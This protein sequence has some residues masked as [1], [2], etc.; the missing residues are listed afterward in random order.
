LPGRQAHRSREALEL[1][2]QGQLEHGHRSR[3]A[4]T[5]PVRHTSGQERK[6][7]A[8]NAPGLVAAGDL[9]FS[10]EQVKGFV[11]A[12]VHVQRRR[13]AGRRLGLDQRELTPGFGAGCL[14]CHEMTEEPE[15]VAFLGLE[16]VAAC[17]LFHDGS[18]VT[19]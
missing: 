12:M 10:V 14:E 15:R 3:V 7:T 6:A 17:R 8:P 2:W 16:R 1:G 5:E 18:P 19:R 4:D 9:H 13:E 11:F